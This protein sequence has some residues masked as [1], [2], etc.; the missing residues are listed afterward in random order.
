MAGVAGPMLRY[1]R[2]GGV[3][4]L[5]GLV[6][7]G[8]VAGTLLAVPAYLLGSLLRAVLS[9]PARLWLLAALCV[10]LGAADLMNRTPHVWRQV[11][12]QMVHTLSPGALGA[13]WGFDLGL[14]FTTQKVVSLIW[15]ALAATML[16]DPPAAAG[17]LASI[18]VLASLSVAG[19]SAVQGMAKFG[20]G[21]GV[22]QWVRRI[23]RMSGV[24]LMI[25]FILTSLQ[26][27]QG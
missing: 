17:V 10:L 20:S 12:Q 11:P 14:L 1:N 19:L 22:R 8:A 3:R 9:L 25:L 21:R 18:A 6:V 13:V 5:V 23:R 27:W 4:F 15:V 2:R 24:A 16:L 7:G 26:A